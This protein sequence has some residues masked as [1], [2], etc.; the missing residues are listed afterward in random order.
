MESSTIQLLKDGLW[1]RNIVLNQLLALCPLLA[2]TTTAINGLGMGIATTLV[3]VLSNMGV[4]LLRKAIAR[5]IRIPCFVVIIASVVTVVD[6]MMNAYVHDLHKVLGLF[7]PLIVTNCAVLGRA[8]SFGYRNKVL[9]S[10]L[11]GLFMGLGFAWSLV[12]IGA[13]RELTGSG[14][15]FQGASLLGGKLLAPLE[16]VVIPDYRGFVIS[17]LPPGGFLAVGL[18]LAGKKAWESRPR[19]SESSELPV[20]S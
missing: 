7:I 15:L 11:D 18:V 12:L 8:E 14:T 1:N 19:V 4:S 9:P 5:D 13:L 6:Q 10:A 2:V 16:T 20:L 17:I 3:L